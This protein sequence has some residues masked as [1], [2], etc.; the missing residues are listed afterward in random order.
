METVPTATYPISASDKRAWCVRDRRV[1]E[2]QG[3]DEAS[4]LSTP[5][6]LWPIRWPEDRSE[7]PNLH[8]ERRHAELTAFGVLL[9]ASEED[10]VA[11][12]NRPRNAIV[13]AHPSLA[14]DDDEELTEAG[15][16]PTDLPTRLELQQ[17]SVRLAASAGKMGGAS[18]LGVVAGD[19]LGATTAVLR[20]ST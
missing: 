3:A 5:S 12:V 10:H 17:V 11:G 7:V 16:V 8:H 19:R 20:M 2:R 18:A 6:T 14:L 13:A 4:P 1:P 15:F 9:A